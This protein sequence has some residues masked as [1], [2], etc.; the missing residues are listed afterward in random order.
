M[1]NEEL[2]LLEQESEK[3]PVSLN[4]VDFEV[5]PE[6]FEI[7]D[8]DDDFF[9]EETPE[10][11]QDSD[12]QAPET[13]GKKKASRTPKEGEGRQVYEKAA[14]QTVTIYDAVMSKICMAIAM[15]DTDDKYRLTVAEKRDLIAVTADFIEIKGDFLTPEQKFYSFVATMISVSII[16]AIS[17]RQKKKRAKVVAREIVQKTDVE[18]PSFEFNFEEGYTGERKQF[19]VHLDTGCYQV[20]TGGAY[21]KVK[22]SNLKAPDWICREYAQKVKKEKWSHGRFNQH[23]LEILDEMVKDG[24]EVQV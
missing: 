1:E 16:S 3:I 13:E 24:K 20:T 10:N 9:G 7:T 21:L 6:D 19:Q 15:A 23:I 11:G 12:E 14:R 5:E 18:S 17:D 22:E 8:D 4:D 2:D